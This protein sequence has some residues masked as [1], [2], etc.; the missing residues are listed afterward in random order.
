MI[1]V[2]DSRDE[3]EEE[4][5]KCSQ[6][7]LSLDVVCCDSKPRGPGE[8]RPALYVEDT[9]V[10]PNGRRRGAKGQ[11][12]GKGVSQSVVWWV[13]KGLAGYVQAGAEG[14]R[15]QKQESKDCR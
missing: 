11:S 5:D 3:N 15:W 1:N 13:P 7:P 6:G 4:E 2:T 10:I 12:G 14:G 9:L 8:G